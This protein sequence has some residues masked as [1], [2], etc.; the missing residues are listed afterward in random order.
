MFCLFIWSCAAGC[1][2]SFMGSMC[3]EF[4]RDPR[5]Q[6]RPRQCARGR[7]LPGSCLVL[8]SPG[9]VVWGQSASSFSEHVPQSP[10]A[11]PERRESASKPSEEGFRGGM[12]VLSGTCGARWMR[13]GLRGPVGVGSTTTG[14]RVTCG[15]QG[16]GQRQ[17]ASEGPRPGRIS[18]FRR[19]A[20]L[21][22]LR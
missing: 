12:G 1:S 17:V 9:L 18:S 21:P 19:A 7:A 8:E 6:K 16:R 14:A 10:Q 5:T 22:G 13:G 15:S 2:K 20:P 3:A 4:V 11:A